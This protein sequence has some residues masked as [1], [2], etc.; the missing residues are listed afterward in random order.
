M[1]LDD[2]DFADDLTSVAAV[3]AAIGLNIH[4][5]K[6]RL[7]DAKQHAPIKSLDG[8]VFKDVETFADLGSIIDEQGRSYADVK[9]R[10]SKARKAY[11]KLKNIKISK[12]FSTKIDFRIINRNVKIVLLYGVETWRT[13]KAITQKIQVFI[14]S[15]LSKLL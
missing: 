14:N 9:V 11:L 12:Q 1:R 2:L 5:E 13:T 15:C 7:S 8:E 3:P 10:I 6:T 4:E